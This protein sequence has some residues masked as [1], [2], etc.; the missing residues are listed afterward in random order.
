MNIIYYVRSTN[1]AIYRKVTEILQLIFQ[2]S[3]TSKS[4]SFLS[5]YI[6]LTKE[7]LIHLIH[8]ALFGNCHCMCFV[9]L[10]HTQTRLYCYCFQII[11]NTTMNWPFIEINAKYWAYSYVCS[12]RLWY[13]YC[14]SCITYSL[15]T[16]LS[17]R[18]F[19]RPHVHSNGYV[20]NGPR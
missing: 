9:P 20:T 15:R 13:V 5:F 10:Q 18:L 11:R 3:S 2:Q 8:C 17:V 6:V 12:V 7:Y 16:W 4:V 19:I 14:G 1:N